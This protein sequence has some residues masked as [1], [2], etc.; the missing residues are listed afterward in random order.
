MRLRFGVSAED[1]AV[2]G[3]GGFAAAGEVSLRSDDQGLWMDRTAENLSTRLAPCPAGAAADISGRFVCDDLDASLTIVGEGDLF[4]GAFSG[5]LG[6]G[7]MELLDPIGQDVWALPC[8]RALDHNPPGDWTLVFER[9]G[10]GTA[11]SVIVGC[12]LARGLT[13][14][15]A[16]PVQG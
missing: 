16:S 8:P 3:G 1:L 11:V 2:G 12:W 15:R 13:Y 9:D 10:Q 5:L 14:R 6:S 4:Y 7:R